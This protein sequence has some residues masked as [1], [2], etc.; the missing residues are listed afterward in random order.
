M[1]GRFI[2][3]VA[4]VSLTC[5]VISC[6]QATSVDKQPEQHVLVV[7]VT[8]NGTGAIS[9]SPAG[10]ACSY[11]GTNA[12]GTCSASFVSGTIVT[13]AATAVGSH[14]FAGWSGA[15]AGTGTCQLTMDQGRAV[16]ATFTAP[17]TTYLLTVTG[18]GT[19]N[20]T[21]TSNP[22]GIN[23]TI[24]GGG[25]SGNCG[26]NSYTNGTIVTLTATPVGS[27]T[28][29]GWSGACAGTGN[30][31]VTLDRARSVTA[32]FTAPLTFY[33]LTVTGAGTGDGSVTSTPSG[34]DCTISGGYLNGHCGPHTYT[35]GTTVT[36]TAAPVGGH[37][38]AGWSGACAGTGSCQVT[39]DQARSVSATFMAPT[40]TYLLTVTGAGSGDGTV[41]SNPSG[42]NCTISSG[43]GSG[44]C[45][46]RSYNSGTVVTLT[47]TPLTGHTFAGWFGACAGTGNCQ[48]TMDRALSVTATFTVPITTYLLTV[49]GS[50]TGSGSVTSSP[51]GINCTISGSSESGT[52]SASY[53]SGTLITLTTTPASGHAF[54]GWSGACNGAGSCQVT[55]S[56]ARTVTATFTAPL[57]TRLLTVTGSGTG[58][59]S[60][61]SSPSGINCTISGSSE[62]GTCSAS[63][64]SGTLITLTA[65]PASGHTF[66]GWSGACSG[67]GSCQ[68]TMSQARTVTATFTAPLTTHLLTV[69]GSGTGSGSVTSSPSGIN[70]S[71]SGGGESGNCGPHA[72]TSGTVVTLTAAPAGGHTFA[73][74]SGACSGSGSCQV[75]MSQART[76]TATFTAPLIASQLVLTT[77]PSSTTQSGVVFARQPVVQLRDVSGNNVNKSGVLVTARI[78]SGAGTLLGT[79]TVATNS[80]GQARFT[81]LLTCRATGAGTLQFSASG[82]ASATSNTITRTPRI[83]RFA[84]RDWRVEAS[85]GRQNPGLNYWS[86]CPGSVW[87]DSDS[88]LHLK[89]MQIA[90]NWHAAQVVSVSTTRY[91]MHR[92]YVD[93][94]IDLLDR[95]LVFSPFLYVTG[96]KELDIE[97]SRWG[98]QNHTNAQFF[99]QP[100]D[101][102]PFSFSLT[103]TYST[104]YIDW[105]SSQV[106]F[107][108]I[109]GHHQEPP[110]SGFLI[111]QWTYSGSRNPRESD[112]L[113]II[114][115]LYLV[116]GKDQPANGQ[117]AEIVVTRAELP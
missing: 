112:G 49:T 27:H 24:S 29:V 82:I 55:M 56:Q 100:Y 105:S 114:I 79:T 97:F 88:S 95:N 42:I 1:L 70:C 89:V 83:I 6:E 36:L 108:S 66:A 78:L 41:T 31:Q 116:A 64:N 21:V 111:H 30:C 46:P 106:R 101:V 109:H 48:I 113:Q 33:P 99:V 54:A 10:V 58:S 45:G 107:K 50:G 81:D 85:L 80:S 44:N 9:T 2:R 67:A 35:S 84:R 94:R 8:G 69:T 20:G 87:V 76:V 14:I 75:T 110:N 37:T 3:S 26:P 93:G 28:F 115:I 52:C 43:G 68:V 38:F 65:T 19:G 23:C 74:W 34:I 57:T 63:Y 90:G 22:S 92:F 71:I 77:Q 32:T 91:G 47:A 61:T 25:W 5:F 51:T 98:E 16:S 11:S 15:C 39:M 17:L 53:N 86:D 18:A 7:S 40:T 4:A 102:H 60:V 96:P 117:T 12:S 72:Y 59:G 73:G 13:L 103:G 104:H 62:S